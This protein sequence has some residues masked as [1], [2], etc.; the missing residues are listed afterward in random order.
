M[1]QLRILMILMV[2]I[3]FVAQAVSSVTPQKDDKGKWGLIDATGSYVVNPIYS[4][5]ESLGDEQFMVAVGGKE[6]DGI[7]EGEKWGVIDASG[8]ILL[9]AQYNEIGEFTNGLATVMLNDKTGFVNTEWKIV[10][11]PKYDFVGTPNEQ[12]F[13]WVNAGGKP[14]K[15]NPSRISRGKYG[16]FDVKGNP[17]VP[18]QYASI[19][20][21]TEEKSSYSQS[22]IYK[23][24]SEL[25]RAML[26]SGSHQALWAKQLKG[27]NG[28]KIPVSI[29]FAFSKGSNLAQNGIIGLDGAILVKNGVYQRCAMPSDGLALVITKNNK[30]GFHEVSTGK[31]LTNNNIQ[32]AFSFQDNCAVGIDAKNKWHF[33]DKSFTVRGEAYDWISPRF[34]KYYIV[35]D[36]AE[37]MLLNASD[38]SVKVKGKALIYPPSHGLMAFK[39]A[40]TNKW[41]FLNNNGEIALPPKYEYAFSFRHGVGYV[42]GTEG[43]GIINSEFKELIAPRWKTYNFPSSDNFTKVWV[44]DNSD[45]AHC[46]S[47]TSGLPV[48]SATFDDGWNFITINNREYAAVKIGNKHGY[49]NDCGNLVIPADFSYDEARLALDYKLSHNITEWKTIHSYRFALTVNKK[50]NSYNLK[51]TVPSSLWDY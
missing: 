18:V 50:I 35:K 9:K 6:N 39:D 31:L 20:Y 4:D 45:K 34:D 17:V 27:G 15:A 38:F 25:E 10:I 13:V 8:K 24:K 36:G 47:I 23:A 51:E 21:I 1:T 42:K 46:I 11:P 22:D 5:I 7:L 37:M 40:H 28:F 3:P 48:F 14:D 32:S 29:G 26:E 2:I 43:W 49:I 16:I 33:L 41:G 44:K 19:G 12:G 30:V